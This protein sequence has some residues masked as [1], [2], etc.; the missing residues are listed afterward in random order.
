MPVDPKRAQ[1][2]FLMAV[3]LEGRGDRAAVL[4]RECATD[5][6]L[7]QRVSTLLQ[8][9]D[10]PDIF[11]DQPIV[12]LAPQ[13]LA[14]LAR[15]EREASS[16]RR[17]DHTRG[18]TPAPPGEPASGVTVKMPASLPS[19]EGT[20]NRIGP[21]KLLQKIGEGGM[22][23]VYMAEQQQPVRRSVALK[24]IKPGMD[25]EQ[26]IA[27]FE[28]ERQ[29]LALMDHQNI[30][31]VL[32]AGTT[33]TGRPF[34]VMEL[35]HGVSITLYCNQSQLTMRERL[36]LFMPVCQAIQHAHQNGIIHRDIKP[37]NVL[38]TLYDGK[39]VAKVIDF[40]VAKAIG[41]RLTERTMFTQYGSIIGTFE[42]MSPEQAEM[43]ALGVD[44]RSDIYS[45]G[46]LLYELLTGTTPLEREKTIGS[47]YADILRRIREEEPP[48]PS[49][50][51]KGSKVTLPFLSAQRKSEP[52]RLT[53]LMRG[54]LDWIVM[55][56][57]EKDR[58]RRYETAS[59]FAR[60]IQRHLDGDVVEACPPSASYRLRKFARKN[61]AALVTVGSFALLLLVGAVLS[62]LQAIR[63]TRAES[64][65]IG[66]TKRAMIAEERSRFER[67]RAIAAEARARGESERAERSAAEA[68]AVLGFFQ[69]QV[70]SAAR[71][72]GLEGGLGKDVTLRT[73]VDVAEPKIAGAFF[74]QPTT[75]ASI[76]SVLGDTYYYLGEPAL[77]VRQR[78]RALELRMARLGPD[79]S[80]TLNSQNS[81]ALAYW[82]AGQNDRAIP[83]LEGTVAVRSGKLGPD[84]PDTLTSQ[85]NLALA[86][87]AAGEL[88]R[89]IPLL[90]QTVAA[91]SAKLG[92]DHPDT[93]IS[94]S[95]LAN[96]YRVTG[97]FERA[98]LLSER[99]LATQT[100]K[101]GPDHPDTITSRNNLANTYRDAGHN[102]LAIP[103]LER[104][105]EMGTAKLGS[106]HPRVL[107]TR[108]ILAVAY[109]SA[110]Q[111]DRAIPLFE[112]TLAAQ[113]ARLGRDHPD[114]L[115]SQNNLANAY[116]EAGQNVSAIPL[117]ERTMKMLSTKLGP[118]HIRTLATQSSLANAYRDAGQLDRSIPLLE[119]TVAASSAKLGPDHAETLTSQYNLALAYQAAGELDRAIP[120]LERTLAAQAAKLGPDHPSMLTTRFEL[121]GAY[122]ARGDSARAESL[123]R[124]VLVARRKKLGT[125]HPQ[126]AETLSSLGRNLLAQRKW[127]EAEPL[128]REGLA[129]W[130]ARRPDDWNRFNTLSLLG[131]SLLGQKKFGEAEP[132]LRAGYEGMSA[133]EAKLPAA[134]KIYLAEAGERN[135][136][137]YEVWGKNDEAR[138]WRAKLVEDTNRPKVGASDRP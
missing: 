60:D 131:H 18:C 81:L 8:S 71:P 124:E 56:A 111:I 121:A 61:R 104:T 14:N 22:G 16:D 135:A 133:R 20:G 3:E 74:D 65:A 73:V 41:E 1:A 9:N 109:L 136:R 39:P 126:F 89:A 54:E 10:E 33:D 138:L 118:D 120:M 106:D 117:L 90:E 15:P 132:L 38:V 64:A 55:K 78:Q 123:L 85:N 107:I 112:Q 110:G 28:A 76:R 113:T 25:S 75:E 51:L 21:Y 58:T 32:D 115:T 83:L 119:R 45:L 7:R 6:E 102:D 95:H 46:V 31:R 70:L 72:E 92:P 130:D 11:L 12:G 40:G 69:D 97:Q 91:R 59:A 84:H 67:D 103:L 53:K 86:Y 4:D 100:A 49:T 27:R 87:K 57:L 137:L 93:L 66:Q 19:I 68:R 35:V 108:S 128:L 37:S 48:K 82:A 114:T 80:D 116:R 63:A 127:S 44:T 105:L 62:S 134:K 96:G 101:L 52:A 77:A 24:I 94:Q 122:Q 5:P 13:S 79:H 47:A 43:S 30:A 26:V 129:I 17:A 36:E 2:V 23:A 99:T 98:L 50:R 42:Y 125:Q 88:D 34:F 29:A